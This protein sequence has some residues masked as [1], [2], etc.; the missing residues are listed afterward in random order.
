MIYAVILKTFLDSELSEGE[1]RG[2]E[3]GVIIT[4]SRFAFQLYDN[5]F[6]CWKITAAIIGNKRSLSYA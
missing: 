3:E 2:G 4:K 1:G 5:I 6:Y